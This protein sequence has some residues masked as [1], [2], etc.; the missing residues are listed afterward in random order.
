[1]EPL[2]TS[3]EDFCLYAG[4]LGTILSLACLVQVF[5]AFNSHWFT[6]II[7]ILFVFTAISYIML[8]MHHRVAPLLVLISGILI[9]LY[10]LLL[11]YLFLTATAIVF[12]WILLLLLIYSNLI[13]I[14]VYAKG[15]PKKFNL[16][17]KKAKEEKDYWNDKL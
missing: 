17:A 8:I 2:D 14:V 3:D 15:L 7:S 4:G 11:V 9:L 13:T 12:S 1:M 10:V 6:T 16:I 5:M